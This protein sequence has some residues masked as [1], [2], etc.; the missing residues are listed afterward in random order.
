MEPWLPGIERQSRLL[1]QSL[2]QGRTA[3]G[4]DGDYA[5]FLRYLQE[6]RGPDEQSISP[7]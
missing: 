4:L 5:R 6:R 2:D 7:P 1:R 3:D